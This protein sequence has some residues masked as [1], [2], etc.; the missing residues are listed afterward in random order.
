MRMNRA[1][2]PS[3]NS[4][5]ITAKACCSNCSSVIWSILAGVAI[6]TSCSTSLTTPKSSPSPV[7]S[8]RW[9]RCPGR[10]GGGGEVCGLVVG[11]V[12][13]DGLLLGID[14]PS[15][16]DSVRNPLLHLGSE[17]G[18]PVAGRAEF[19]DEVRAEWRCAVLGRECGRDG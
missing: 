13:G 16:L 12:D 5:T 19:D 8:R 6:A 4:R 7:R 18:E 15:D 11:A 1:R 10:W 14:Q 9:G 3:P 17:V 2:P